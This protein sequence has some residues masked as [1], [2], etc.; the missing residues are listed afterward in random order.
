MA[1]KR[2]VL[3]LRQM[4]DS[5]HQKEGV[6]GT[7]L[8]LSELDKI[9]VKHRADVLTRQYEKL[10]TRASVIRSEWDGIRKVRG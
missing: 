2:Q 9:A 5:N 10:S 3:Q 4:V 1:L 7:G 8:R 6:A